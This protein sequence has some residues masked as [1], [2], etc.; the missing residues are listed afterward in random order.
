MCK[1]NFKPEKETKN[2]IMFSEILEGNMTNPVIGNVYFQKE[3]LKTMDW[4]EGKCISLTIAVTDEAPAEGSTTAAEK[5]KAATAKFKEARAAKKTAA[6]KASVKKAAAKTGGKTMAAK[7]VK[8]G[9]AKAAK[10]KAKK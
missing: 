10:A 3:S 6:K 8:T 1:I 7:A 9:K 4:K 2:T 5:A